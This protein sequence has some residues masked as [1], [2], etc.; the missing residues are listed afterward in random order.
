MHEEDFWS[1]WPREDE[2]GKEERT[3]RADKNEEEKSEKK[4]RE[5]AREENETETVERRCEGFV[6]VEA[7]EIFGQGRHLESCGDLSWEDTME[8]IGNWSDCESVSRARVRVVPDVTD[9]LVSPSSVV[10]LVALIGNLQSFSFLKKR[11]LCCTSTQ[12][13]MRYEGSQ[14][15]APPITR[16]RMTLPTPVQNSYTSLERVQGSYE[17]EGQRMEC[18][19]ERTIIARTKQYLERSCSVKVRL[20]NWKNCWDQK[21]WMWIS[22]ES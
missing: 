19:R 18:E 21:M 14:G 3:A 9:V 16:R 7:F 10:L 11:T 17:G 22:G 8:E 5:E 4:K 12:E 2:R 6:S 1:S 13:E 15:K 20:K